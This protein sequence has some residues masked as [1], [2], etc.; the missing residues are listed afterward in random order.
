MLISEPLIYLLI[1]LCGAFIAAFVT[2]AV[3]FADGLI[4]NAFWLHILEPAS[5]IPLVI[6][7]GLLIH[8]TPLYKLRK[9][10]D[11][12][13]LKPFVVCG[14][15]GAPLGMWILT[16]VD[17][18]IFKTL[19]GLL[20]LAYG[21]WMLMATNLSFNI[22]RKLPLDGFIGL[23]GGLMCGF[24]GLGGLLPTIWVG[25]QRLPK[26]LQ[27]GTYEPFILIVNLVAIIAFFIADLFTMQVGYDLLR[28]LPALI[29]G[30]WL[31]VKIYPFIN[32]TVFQKTVLGLILL[33]GLMLLI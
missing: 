3:G 7:S 18:A 13:R 2:G 17:P 33:S 9:T 11:F 29:L 19:I 24:A 30:S 12:S 16:F 21:F 28:A 20:L 8:V 5:A 15:I 26:N 22:S 1:L 10:L 32:D 6:V 25:M 4:L 31:G 23:S 27:R 14:A